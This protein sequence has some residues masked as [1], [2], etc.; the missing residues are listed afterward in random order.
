MFP[1]WLASAEGAWVLAAAGTLLAG[2]ESASLP[3]APFLILYALALPWPG[4]LAGTASF[5]EPWTALHSHPM[6]IAAWSLAILAWEAG[7]MG[8]G[9]EAWAR[10]SGGPP[11]RMSAT[12]AMEALLE[13]TGRR[14]GL[15]PAVVGAWSAG[16]FLLWAPLAEELFFWGYLYP[17]WRPAYGAVGAS[18]LV[19]AWF[20]I[21]HGLHFLFLPRP[22]PWPAAAAFMA[23]A[24]GAA[25]GNGLL[26]EACGTLWPL[27]ALHFVSNLLSLAAAPRRA[28]AANR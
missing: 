17:V 2:L 9:Y 21:R 7:V 8:R 27:I 16:Y 25:F 20:A 24:G 12:A 11:E 6:A 23:S 5:A 15:S 1:A 3:W 22:Y 18:A 28:P 14:R 26:F 19:A 13:E 10:R 4:L